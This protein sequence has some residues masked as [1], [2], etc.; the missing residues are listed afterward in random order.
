MV[1]KYTKRD[2]SFI[3]YISQNGL[4]LTIASTVWM[5]L[6]ACAPSKYF[7][8]DYALQKVNEIR[9]QGCYCGSEYMAPVNPLEWNNVLEG[10][11]YGHALE[12]SRYNYFSHKSRDGKDIGQRLDAAGYK[13]QFAGENLA[14]GQKSFNETILDWLESKTH[15]KMLMNPRMKETGMARY[16]KYWVQHFGT[17]MPPNTVRKKVY[18]KEG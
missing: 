9:S 3:K 18:Y 17:H 4:F 7:D 14:E 10:T 16:G 6:G 2:F 15:C 12:M 11:A 13:W 5:I 1:F 8:P